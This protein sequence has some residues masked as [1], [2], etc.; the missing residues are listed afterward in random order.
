M[1]SAEHPG[2]LNSS[3]SNIDMSLAAQV[4][5][6]TATLVVVH[7]CAPK[8]LSKQPLS[9]I[10][11]VSILVLIYLNFAISAEGIG[12]RVSSRLSRKLL[13][14]LPFRAGMLSCSRGRW[15]TR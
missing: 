12:F 10:I 6:L 9:L 1:K 2:D 7:F 3:M 11:G 14:N 5:S 13:L 4:H 15:E 8:T